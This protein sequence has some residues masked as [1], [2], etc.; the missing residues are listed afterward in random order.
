MQIYIELWYDKIELQFGK[1]FF[2][3]YFFLEKGEDIIE[4]M[5]FPDSYV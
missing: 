4:G 5:H 3:Q 1:F 2:S